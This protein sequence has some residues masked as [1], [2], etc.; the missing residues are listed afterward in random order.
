M[1][2][3]HTLRALA[4]F[5][6][7]TAVAVAPAA[8][9]QVGITEEPPASVSAGSQ[10]VIQAAIED[11]YGNVETTDDA[12]VATVCGGDSCRICSASSSPIPR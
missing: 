3:F 12:V 7:L 1:T 10:F 5:A 2:R 4:C 11:A 8:A 6:V 9:S